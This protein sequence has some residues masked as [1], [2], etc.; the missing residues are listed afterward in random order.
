MVRIPNLDESEI[1][2]GPHCRL[3]LVLKLP[4]V[5]TL[6]SDLRG[7]RRVSH[8][9]VGGGE[10]PCNP[11][12]TWSGSKSETEDSEALLSSPGK[13]GAATSRH[14][15]GARERLP[16]GSRDLAAVP[17]VAYTAGLKTFLLVGYPACPSER[18]FQVPLAGNL[19]LSLVQLKIAGEG[20]TFLYAEK[21]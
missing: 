21:A 7:K 19:E 17:I 13:R 6:P 12:D 14:A 10:E 20:H 1:W 11:V 4:E 5:G 9:R 3:H 16:G 2:Y 8:A 18:G 15:C